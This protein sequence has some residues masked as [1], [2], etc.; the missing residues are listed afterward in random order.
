MVGGLNQVVLNLQVLKEEFS[1]FF[2][3]GHNASDFCR[4]DK[5]VFG[6]LDLEKP[7]HRYWILKVQFL[8]AAPNQTVKTL[9]FQ[10][11]PDGAPHEA[12]MTCDVNAGMLFHLH[13]N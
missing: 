10:F 7:I 4:R 6:L 9:A 11:A 2:I 5:Y 3:V 8:A 13:G 1:R 12:T